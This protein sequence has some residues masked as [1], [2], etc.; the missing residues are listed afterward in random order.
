MPHGPDGRLNKASAKPGP[1][2]V[3]GPL[4]AG[5]DGWSRACAARGGRRSW[6][7]VFQR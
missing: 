1:V 5:S 2:S 7:R 6:G 4:Q 3:I